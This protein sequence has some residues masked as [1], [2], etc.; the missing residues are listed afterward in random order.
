MMALFVPVATQDVITARRKQFV[1]HFNCPLGCKVLLFSQDELRLILWHRQVDS[2]NY[3]QSQSL[4]CY[5][6]TMAVYT[7]QTHEI[8]HCPTIWAT[9]KTYKIRLE[10][11][12]NIF[13]SINCCM[14]LTTRLTYNKQFNVLLSTLTSPLEYLLR[15]RL[16]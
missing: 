14:C 8:K 9:C 11:I 7:Y 16:N 6:Y 1:V 10:L 13:S 15:Y 4:L 2:N 3:L 12:T 5:H